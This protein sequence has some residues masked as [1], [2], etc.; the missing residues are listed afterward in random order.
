MIVCWCDYCMKRIVEG[1]AQCC[2]RFWDD[3]KMDFCGDCIP[4]MERCT[5]KITG[6][7]IAEVRDTPWEKW[8]RHDFKQELLALMHGRDQIA[9]ASSCA[10]RQQ[11]AR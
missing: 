9:T 6:M 5:E 11:P 1:A 2:V 4:S 10:G 3:S 7:T 8:M